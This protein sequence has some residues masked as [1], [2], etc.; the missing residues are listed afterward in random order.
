ME[1]ESEEKGHQE[2]TDQVIGFCAAHHFAE[3]NIL[4]VPRSL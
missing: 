2:N 1:W 4:N 3:L